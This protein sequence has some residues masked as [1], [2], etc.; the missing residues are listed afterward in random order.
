MHTRRIHSFICGVFVHIHPHSIPLAGCGMQHPRLQIHPRYFTL[1]HECMMVDSFKITTVAPA[2]S[3]ASER[4]MRHERR[5]GVWRCTSKNAHKANVQA[6]SRTAQDCSLL[7][8]V[9]LGSHPEQGHALCHSDGYTEG[10]KGCARNAQMRPI[11]PTRPSMRSCCTELL[12]R[13]EPTQKRWAGGVG[14]PWPSLALSL[15]TTAAVS[16]NLRSWRQATANRG[17]VRLQGLLS[18]GEHNTTGSAPGRQFLIR[19]RQ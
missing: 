13:P 2:W 19:H 15:L 18:S 12:R 8:N 6:T 5:C 16:A 7:R 11:L 3:V 9:V 14:L 4:T 1:P 17:P 10:K